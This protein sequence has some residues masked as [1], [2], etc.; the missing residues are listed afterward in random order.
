MEMSAY[1]LLRVDQKLNTLWRKNVQEGKHIGR[2]LSASR[3]LS[4]MENSIL[5]YR[6]LGH[7]PMQRISSCERSLIGSRWISCC[8][9]WLP[10]LPTHQSYNFLI[11]STGS[12]LSLGFIDVKRHQNQGTGAGLQVQSF[13]QLSSRQV[14]WQHWGR[15]SSGEEAKSSVSC[16]ED[17]QNVLQ[18][19][20]Q[21]V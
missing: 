4:S 15:H 5:I 20:M 8:P 10:G 13:S 14:A 17:T 7:V 12:H 16:C 6:T 2:T 3:Y 18:V 1:H 19:D 11:W 21:K 9:V